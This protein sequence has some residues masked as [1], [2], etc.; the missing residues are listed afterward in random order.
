MAVGDDAGRATM[1]RNMELTMMQV[2]ETQAEGLKREFK[3]VIPAT[4]VASEVDTRLQ[5]LGV[6]VRM[7]GFRPGKVPMPMLKQRFGKSVMGEV[8]ERAV[9]ESSNKV[10]ADRGLRAVGQPRVEIVSFAEGSDL[11]YKLAIELMPEFKPM[12][13][14]TIKLERRVVDV[15]EGDVDT[16]L[17]RL[18]ER[19]RDS[20]P[21]QSPRPA[22]IGDVVAIDFVGRIDGKDFAGGS[23]N[24][25]HIEL[26]SG[27][28]IAG[29]EDQLLGRGAGEKVDVAVTFPDDYPGKEVAGKAAIFAVDIREIREPVI[30]AIDDEFAKALGATDLADLRV[31]MKKQIGDNYAAL[32]RSK[33]KRDLLDV[34]DAGHGFLLPPGMVQAEFDAIW[35]Q[36]S[37]AKETGTLDPDDVGKSDEQLRKEYGAIA[38][39]RVRLGLLLSEV[40]RLNS[41]QITQEELNRA[42]IA[43]ARRHPGQETKVIELFKTNPDALVQLRAPLYE[44]KVVNF[45][46]ELAQLSERQVT[47]DEL[48]EAVT[49]GAEKSAD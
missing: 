40:G 43:E 27:N 14:G 11:E 47:A 7:P 21:L 42:V 1:S 22:A 38:E 13:F 4:D 39:R 25:H 36:I 31:K 29:F 45:I 48:Q 37:K 19:R 41:V 28:L 10:V 8:V 26:G 23:A 16:A 9:S 44:D 2:I 33:L 20:K 17:Q 5:K 18:A 49:G 35:Q 3:V 15:A 32:S 6:D 30:P 12:D 46:L 24:G 34:L